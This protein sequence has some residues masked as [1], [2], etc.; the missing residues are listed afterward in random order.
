MHKGSEVVLLKDTGT[1]NYRF[2]KGEVFIIIQ[3]WF[4]YHGFGFATI[5]NKQGIRIIIETKFLELI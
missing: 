5:E 2:A 3:T 1:I 4:D